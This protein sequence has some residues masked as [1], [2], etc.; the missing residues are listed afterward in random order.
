MARFPLSSRGIRG[1]R[2]PG[3]GG[4]GGSG[5]TTFNTRAGAVTLAKADVTGTSLAATDLTD[6]ALLARLASPTFTGTPAAPTATLGD[7][8]TKLATTAFVI[9]NAT[10][11]TGV[12]SFNTR[13]GTVTLTKADVTGT[14]LA[15]TD[16]TDT[17]LLARLASPALTGN[18]TAPTQAGGDNSTKLAT[19]AFVT[20]ATS[21]T[22][23]GVARVTADVTNAG[24]TMANVTG[25]SFAIAASDIWFVEYLLFIVPSSASGIGFQVT[26][27]ASPT[28]VAFSGAASTDSVGLPV[29]LSVTAFSSPIG[30][31]IGFLEASGFSPVSGAVHLSL[32]VKNGSNA[33]TVQLQFVGTSASAGASIREGS[34]MRT[35]K[36][37]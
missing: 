31:T 23:A 25:L 27:P 28:K 7:N 18:P 6:T 15:A 12:T 24:T 34:I 29:S 11:A 4:G 14:S 26:G 19:T 3:S 36:L 32:Y 10:G 30:G 13:T 35:T 21:G 9:A 33:G 1:D 22:G 5:V 8:T 20:A 17:A 37:T 2:K 16:L